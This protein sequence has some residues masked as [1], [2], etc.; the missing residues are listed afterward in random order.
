M[1]MRGKSGTAR[2]GRNEEIADGRED[3]KEPLQASRKSKALHRPLSSADGKVR[4]FCAIVETLVR[5]MLHRRH[6]LASSSGVRAELVG[7]QQPGRTALLLQETRQQPLGRL[8][9][10]VCLHDLI[11]YISVLI[12]DSPKP[13]F[14]AG[15]SDLS[16]PLIFSY[17]I[18]IG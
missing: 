9:V 15:D 18:S 2:K 12:D 11:E 13:V 3:K 5:P 14:L 1:K 8:R 6:D 10:P 17:N 16:H 4:I 7:N